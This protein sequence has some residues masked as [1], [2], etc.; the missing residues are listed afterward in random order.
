[1]DAADC[2]VLTSE[3]EGLPMV[4]LEALALATPV[5]T[6]AFS[7]VEGVVP[8]GCGVVVEHEDAA[9]ARA[10]MDLVSER[11]AFAALDVDAYNDAALAEFSAAIGLGEEPETP[12]RTRPEGRR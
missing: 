9:V 4:I 11:P 1:M 6:T 5:I 10:M 2:F 12:A 3:H 8:S 7:S